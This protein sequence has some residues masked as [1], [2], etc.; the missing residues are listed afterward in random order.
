MFHI[1]KALHLQ[2]ISQVQPLHLCG[3][4]MSV[5][6]IIFPTL[7]F[8]HKQL[9][10]HCS[11][12]LFPQRLLC[13]SLHLS[14]LRRPAY[15]GDVATQ[16]L[17]ATHGSGEQATTG[18]AADGQLGSR[19]MARCLPGPCSV[20]LLSLSIPHRACPLPSPP[21]MSAPSA[22]RAEMSDAW[23][24]TQQLLLGGLFSPPTWEG[25]EGRTPPPKRRVGVRVAL[26]DK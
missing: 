20:S 22:G 7:S 11:L 12:F 6:F 19:A 5:N 9:L 23:W 26:T 4:H 14:F 24:A 3:P 17:A 25:L 2:P 16:A 21:M 8:P 15:K 1:L 13:L 18:A 10:S